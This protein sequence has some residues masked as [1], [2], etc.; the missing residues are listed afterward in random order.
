MDRQRQT[1][2]LS[3]PGE[4]IALFGSNKPRRRQ[5]RPF[6]LD[7]VRLLESRTEALKKSIECSPY[8]L[9][10]F[11]SLFGSMDEGQWSCITKSPGEKGK[12]H[13]P[14]DRQNEFMALA[15]NKILL[16]YDCESNGYDF[17]TMRKHQTDT[18]EKLE[19]A[20]RENAELR[21]KDAEKDEW[22][23]QIFGGRK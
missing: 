4:Q 9:K 12:K 10:E 14:H 7:E 16:M 17:S 3:L 21:R 18:E 1:K 5:P 15:E 19:A 23:R 11:L 2:N 13:F 6:T 20:L 8:E 22:I